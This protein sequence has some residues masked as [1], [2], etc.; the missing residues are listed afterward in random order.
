M[1]REFYP[2]AKHPLHQTTPPPTTVLGLELFNKAVSEK[3]KPKK[4]LTTSPICGELWLK[5][6]IW[7]LKEIPKDIQSSAFRGA[8][9]H[10]SLSVYSLLGCLH[11]KTGGEK[12]CDRHW[13]CGSS[14]PEYLLHLVKLR[15]QHLPHL[16][17]WDKCKL[18]K[19]A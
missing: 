19:E 12:V 14:I 2:P 16:G 4:G 13:N 5:E 7:S 11:H 10:S 1:A 3:H 8:M 18:S 6:E 15:P 17:T 9:L